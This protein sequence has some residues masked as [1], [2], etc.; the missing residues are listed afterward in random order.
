MLHDHA[1]AVSLDLVEVNPVLDNTNMTGILAA[2]MAQGL[3]G[4]RIL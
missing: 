1:R 3:L 2:E 4:K